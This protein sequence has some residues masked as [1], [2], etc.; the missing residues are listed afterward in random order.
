MLDFEKKGQEKLPREQL[1]GTENG[2]QSYPVP[3]YQDQR[4]AV[5][6]LA[7][8]VNHKLIPCNCN[9]SKRIPIG[10]YIHRHKQRYTCAP[11]C[12]PTPTIHKHISMSVSLPAHSLGLTEA[13][14]P[15]PVKRWCLGSPHISENESQSISLAS[16]PTPRKRASPAFAL[17][18]F[19]FPE[20]ADSKHSFSESHKSSPLL[21]SQLNTQPQLKPL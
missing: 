2:S 3:K 15:S 1:K 10:A 19:W 4:S 14:H 21:P 6:L 11:V 5:S 16:T 12:R 9:A 17:F 20:Q 7:P 18:G 8:C 13:P